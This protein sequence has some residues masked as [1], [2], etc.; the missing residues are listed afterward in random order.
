LALLLLFREKIEELKFL[1][2][3]RERKHG[4]DVYSLAIGEQDS[5]SYAATTNV[6]V[7]F[8]YY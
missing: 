7:C 3:Q 5:S 6:E 4:I 8:Q 2:K 1:Q